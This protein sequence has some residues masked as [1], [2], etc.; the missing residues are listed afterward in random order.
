MFPAFI[1][2]RSMNPFKPACTRS[3]PRSTERWMVSTWVSITIAVRCSA[4]VAAVGCFGSGCT[5]AS[6]FDADIG[7]PGDR[8]QLLDLAGH[9]LPEAFGRCR[10]T[11]DIVQFHP[12]LQFRVVQNGVGLG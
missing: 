10:A 9:E 11:H 12:G 4:N 5:G 1:R 6:L 8:C 2:S 3:C 7:L